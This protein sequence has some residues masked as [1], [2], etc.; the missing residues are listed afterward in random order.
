MNIQ[1]P[2]PTRLPLSS[3]APLFAG[4][5]K[6]AENRNNAFP[7]PKPLADSV[8]L[9]S[10]TTDEQVITAVSRQS[11]LL[12]NLLEASLERASQE[13]YAQLDSPFFLTQV[14]ETIRRS[15]PRSAAKRNP[16]QLEDRRLVMSLI[17][18][19]VAGEPYTPQEWMTDFEPAI[20]NFKSQFPSH[21]V[22]AGQPTPKLQADFRKALLAALSKV[23]GEADLPEILIQEI[24]EQEAQKPDALSPLATFF[25]AF[26]A[27]SPA[28]SLSPVGFDALAPEEISDS[29][30][31]ESGMVARVQEQSPTLGKWFTPPHYRPGG[32]I[33]FA[34]LPQAM[35]KGI[36]AALRMANHKKNGGN[37]QKSPL[38]F[39]PFIPESLPVK[40]ERSQAV[41]V[42]E[43]AQRKLQ[44]LWNP[45][46]NQRLRL[47]SEESKRLLSRFLDEPGRS[48]YSPDSFMAFLRA[49]EPVDGEGQSIEEVKRV[50]ET[51]LEE[52]NNQ[53]ALMLD[54]FE[55]ACPSVL[56]HGQNL[57]KKGLSGEL[58]EVL[59]R[60]D[61]TDRLLAIID[62][63][64][65]RTHMLLKGPAGEGKTFSALGLAQRIANN[66]VPKALRN[67]QMVQLNLANLQAENTYRGDFD[68]NAKSMFSELNQYLNHH[69]HP[70]IVFMD[71]AHLM[72][73]SDGE[74]S[75]LDRLKASGLLERKNLTLIGAVTPADLRKTLLDSDQ[76]VEDRFH[77]IPMPKFSA[78]ETLV[79]LG[80]QAS[81]VE[82][83]NGVEIPPDILK[84]TMRYA[85]AK[86]PENALHHALDV[87]SLSASI[88]KGNSFELGALQDQL[89]RK[90]LWLQT[91]SEKKALKGRFALQLEQTRQE[92][93]QLRLEIE[94]RSKQR[95]AASTEAALP[96]VVQ[97]EHLRE[98][99]AILTGEKVEMLTREEMAKLRN[100]KA[101]LSRHIVGQPE[102]LA[103][104]EQALKKIAIHHKTGEGKNRPIVSMLLPGPTGV[105]K[106]EATKVIAKEFMH[107]N[108]IRLDMSDYQEKHAVSLLTGAPPGYIGYDNG[109]LV[110]L[111]QKN[112]KSVVVFDEIEK[113]HP[114]IFNILLQILEE[115]ELRNNQGQ[116]ISFRNAVIALTSN[117][118]HQELT[119]T[120]LKYRQGQTGQDAA[121]A[122]SQL[123][124]AV[125]QLLTANPKTGQTGFRPE[126][127]GR[128]DYVIPFSPLS[129]QNISQILDIQL[130]EMNEKPVLKD[131]N[132]RI[133]LSDSARQRL[134]A[135]ASGSQHQDEDAPLA[136]G[137][138]EVRSKFESLVYDQVMSEIAF[139]ALD[140]DENAVIT[141]D[142]DPKQPDFQLKT[143]PLP[144]LSIGKE[145]PAEHGSKTLAKTLAFA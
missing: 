58:P 140:E 145:Q 105:G 128:I 25:S 21:S 115:G 72:L 69:P 77:I 50:L 26:N 12:A 111:V 51:L 59:M 44:G 29:S 110:D 116:P 134:I 86:W 80:R 24:R 84:K 23:H 28:S 127:L 97:D 89:Q 2:Q 43:N 82:K 137:A 63:G 90:E 35:S 108:I 6:R 64:G 93:E 101:V 76:T 16:A 135:L 75:W 120:I 33:E 38:S 91:L 42:L 7:P 96:V 113:A 31:M 68:R 100:A 22:A 143:A 27:S 144:T 46:S 32:E 122:T 49:S 19:L 139:G 57:V 1:R 92:A 4:K 5:A 129:R 103:A 102:A 142:Y 119:Q 67:A 136:G 141:V 83:R 37:A 124:K 106:T 114:D 109:G 130:A 126:H 71:D 62:S 40:L 10:V 94:R 123:D 11:P 13:G 70:V 15:P 132:L 81:R 47:A 34:P 112:P 118:N 60:R 52:A 117:L 9:S 133:V 61:F 99:M 18:G 41:K 121:L 48:D 45:Q 131:Q 56:K 85:N 74:L 14:V 20:H 73:K 104:I 79:I 39:E 65:R 125:R 55:K 87:L 3:S 53:K 8:E 98:A 36:D 78:D 66:D 30:S 138:R 17:R 95:E 107:G 88:S 54:Q